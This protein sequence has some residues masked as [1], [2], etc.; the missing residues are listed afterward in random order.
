MEQYIPSPNQ[1]TAVNGLVLDADGM[2]IPPRRPFLVIDELLRKVRL[3]WATVGEMVASIAAEAPLT[4]G[5]PE[6]APNPN[7]VLSENGVYFRWIVDPDFHRE[8][9]VRG[10]D[11]K[12]QIQF[13]K[14]PIALTLELARRMTD[15]SNLETD[16][17]TDF[18]NGFTWLRGGYSPEREF[19]VMAQQAAITHANKPMV[20]E[21]PAA[22]GDVARLRYAMDRINQ[23]RPAMTVL[24]VEIPQTARPVSIPDLEDVLSVPAGIEQALTHQTRVASKPKATPAPTGA[25]SAESESS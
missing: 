3:G 20:F 10:D 1:P 24:P 16:R 8:M 18:W 5:L 12:E 4:Q 2:A 9:I 19:T 22:P 14:R 25:P 11:V 23:N 21:V 13:K 15:S 17:T 6:G 7:D